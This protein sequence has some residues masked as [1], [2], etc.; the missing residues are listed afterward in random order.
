[1]A[2]DPYHIE[3][4]EPL[5]KTLLQRSS[6]FHRLLDREDFIQAGYEALLRYWKN[7]GRDS[8]LEPP[9]GLI[10]R[11][12]FIQAFRDIGLTKQKG[13]VMEPSGYD[14]ITTVEVPVDPTPAA[15]DSLDMT[16][17]AASL[18]DKVEAMVIRA[19]LRGVTTEQLMA[20]LHVSNGRISQ[21][22]TSA[23]NHMRA[24]TAN[25][26]AAIAAAT[27]TEANLKQ[28]LTLAVK[29]EALLGE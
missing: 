13:K 14:D 29:A 16:T 21:I 10:I 28:S 12:G 5:M 11:R 15:L 23:I 9:Y 18:M 1:M 4:F 27:G 3:S 17:L 7:H 22:R 6:F 25:N 20:R 8:E 2:L 26:K 19:T 24:R